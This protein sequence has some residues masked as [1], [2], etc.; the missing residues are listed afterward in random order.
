MIKFKNTS[1]EIFH[2]WF[3]NLIKT[4]NVNE[5]YLY[6][7]QFS[8][9]FRAIILA[10]KANPT[11]KTPVCSNYNIISMLILSKFYFIFVLLV[12]DMNTV[13]ANQTGL[14]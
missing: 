9:I 13:F 6:Y 3:Q 2:L 14:Q 1:R 7:G 11:L 12:R 8:V 10:V 4:Q 5:F